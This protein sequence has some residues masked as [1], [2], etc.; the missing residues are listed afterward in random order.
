M[1]PQPIR[2]RFPQQMKRKSTLIQAMPVR[3]GDRLNKPFDLYGGVLDT[4]TGNTPSPP[5]A[6]SIDYV[7]AYGTADKIID[8]QPLMLVGRSSTL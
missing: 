3:A 7:H 5:S 8:G 1:P 2:T 6:P 4:N